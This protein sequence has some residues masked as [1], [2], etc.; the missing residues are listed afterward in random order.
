[1]EIMYDVQ[2]RREFRGPVSVPL[3]EN[4]LKV[5]A[6]SSDVKKCSTGPGFNL[7]VSD[8][9]RAT[10]ELVQPPAE[11]IH[12]NSEVIDEGDENESIVISM[13]GVFF[14]IIEVIHRQTE[15]T[16]LEDQNL[17]E[18]IF[19]SENDHDDEDEGDDGEDDGNDDEDVVHYSRS[20]N[21]P[22]FN[23]LAPCGGASQ[24]PFSRL[25]SIAE[26]SEVE[27]DI[28][29]PT[30]SSISIDTIYLMKEEGGSQQSCEWHEWDAV[31]LKEERIIHFHTFS[32]GE[33]WT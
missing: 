14:I 25:S 11:T 26:C 1:M 24:R 8:L 12:L 20:A 13:V 5:S 9:R 4:T 16:D 21:H 33:S 10:T 15:T 17:R 7:S 2:F 18:R 27:L 30:P 22:P 6:N 3:A 32:I 19:Q 31:V 28:L 29:T 23:N